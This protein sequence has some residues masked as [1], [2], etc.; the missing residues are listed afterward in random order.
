MVPY[1]IFGILYVAPIMKLLKITKVSYLE[2]TI[3]GIIF[4]R[5]CRHLWYLLALFD[6]FI[7]IIILDFLID[8]KNKEQAFI[9]L[10]VIL[11]VITRKM[12]DIMV[13]N[14]AFYFLFF[15]CVG[16]YLYDKIEMINNFFSEHLILWI[17]LGFLSFPL[18][19][20]RRGVYDE[21]TLINSIPAICF[22]IYLANICSKLYIFN[23]FLFG[24]IL[25]NAIG[26][27]LIYPMLLYFM[28][29]RFGQKEIKPCVLV[30]ITTFIAFVISLFICEIFRL[31]NLDFIFGE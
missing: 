5:N 29:F 2:Y 20:I 28:Y 16:Y 26:I 30:F 14:R 8:G 17:S 24:I 22:Y 9:V 13:T 23:N 18:S 31:L 11:L 19:M 21:I 6:I 7:F 15:F 12:P 4:G 25:R 1:F 3:K 10:S 27:Y